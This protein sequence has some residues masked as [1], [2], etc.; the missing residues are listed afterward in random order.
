MYH[1]KVEMGNKLDNRPLG[2]FILH[3]TRI[4]LNP[5][6]AGISFHR[7]PRRIIGHGFTKLIAKKRRITTDNLSGSTT[8]T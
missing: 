5:R 4:P 8:R 6:A 7:Q 2:M 3:L 1:V